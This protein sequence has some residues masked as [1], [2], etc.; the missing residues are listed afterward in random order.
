MKC[1]LKI[2]RILKG[3]MLEDKN[4]QS[5]YTYFCV[6][7]FVVCIYMCVCITWKYIYLNI[8]LCICKYTFKLHCDE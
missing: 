2:C 4:S 6:Y 8:Y 3:C 7:Y 5:K 1:Y